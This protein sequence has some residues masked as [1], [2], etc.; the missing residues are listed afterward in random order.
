V[1]QGVAPDTIAILVGF[2]GMSVA[3]LIAM[4]TGS[5]RFQKYLLRRRRAYIDCVGLSAM[6]VG[7]FVP[8]AMSTGFTLLLYLA[9]GLLNIAI[10]LAS[11]VSSTLVMDFSRKNLASVDYALQM[12]GIHLGGLTMSALSGLIVAAVGYTQFFFVLALFAILMVLVSIGL[13][14]G[15]WILADAPGPG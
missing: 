7:L 9:V 10:T 15:E 8:I 3:A 5:A 14:R 12:T 6:A 1:D 4:A 2:Y 13:F 11:V